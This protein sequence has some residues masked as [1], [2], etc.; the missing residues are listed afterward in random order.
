MSPLRR[1]ASR[2][3]ATAMESRI[4]DALVDIRP[5]LRVDD[6]R[7]ELAAFDAATATAWLRI[8]GDCS[9]CAASVAMFFEGI[10]A[11]LRM[12]VPEVRAVHQATDTTRDE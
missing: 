2:S 5:L 11:Q 12:R 4:R 9:E 1:A 6:A 7:V 8:E 10:A 3:G